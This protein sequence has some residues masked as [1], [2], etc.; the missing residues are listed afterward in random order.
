MRPVGARCRPRAGRAPEHPARPSGRE[1]K[2][3][4]QKLAD[5]PASADEIATLRDEL[6]VDGVDVAHPA[7]VE[8]LADLRADPG[9]K[10]A[11]YRLRHLP[12]R[13]D[14]ALGGNGGTDAADD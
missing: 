10:L 6:A 14:A 3:A 11:R 1:S 8:L 13:V 7:T 4:A 5:A 12:R 9:D 2:R